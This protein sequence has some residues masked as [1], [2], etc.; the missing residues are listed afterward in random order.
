M[1]LPVHRL[2][3]ARPETA[4]PLGW[5]C[6]QLGMFMLPSSALIAGLLLLVA[7]VAASRRGRFLQ[8]NANR[9]LLVVAALMVIGCFR[10]TSGWLAW[11]GMGNWLPFFWAF[12]GFQSYV[13][14]ATPDAA[15]GCGCWPAR[16]R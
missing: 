1:R 7:L 11:V 9:V 15:W 2:D 13:A 6:F 14:T 4:P 16:C 3:C 12:W 5:R 8:D 10:A